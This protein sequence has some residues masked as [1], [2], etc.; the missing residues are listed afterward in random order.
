MEE[1]LVHAGEAVPHALGEGGNGQITAADAHQTG[2]EDTH[3]QGQEHVEPAQGQDQHQHVG[4]DL[5][6]IE[7]Q[8]L[9]GHDRLR[10]AEDQQEDQGDQC[11]RQSDEEVD[12]ELV[13]HFAALA[14]G[15]SDGKD[16]IPVGFHGSFPLQKPRM[17]VR[18]FVLV[19]KERQGWFAEKI[20][21]VPGY[22]GAAF[23]MQ[24]HR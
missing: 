7:G 4:Q 12:T 10:T 13:A 6:E 21:S 22:R 11:R 20:W 5:D 8:G 24:K 17:L 9:Q 19:S 1:Y 2:G 15:G 16:R 23:F 14:A 18:V 3:G